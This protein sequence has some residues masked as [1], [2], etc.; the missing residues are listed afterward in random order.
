MF[1]EKLSLC[2][3]VNVHISVEIKISI[4]SMSIILRKLYKK[5]IK[6][7]VFISRTHTLH[8]VCFLLESEDCDLHAPLFIYF[9]ENS[10]LQKQN[11]DVMLKVVNDNQNDVH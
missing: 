4:N 5:F 2:S 1:V 3:Q 8:H 11:V 6:I 10:N 7:C 9:H